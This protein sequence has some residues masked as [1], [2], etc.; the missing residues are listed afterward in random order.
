[1]ELIRKSLDIDAPVD[2]V[3]A[4]AVDPTTNPQ[5]IPTSK[6]AAKANPREP[7]AFA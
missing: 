1:V 4:Y 2:E 6:I 3:F 7:E 5:W